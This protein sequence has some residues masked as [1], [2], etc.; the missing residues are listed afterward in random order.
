MIVL[1]VEDSVDSRE[2]MTF[3]LKSNGF[4]VIHAEDGMD[5]VEVAM[6]VKPDVILMDLNLPFVSGWEATRTIRRIPELKDVPIIAISAQT[7]DEWRDAVLA[8][9]AIDCLK[10]PL[11]TNLL[12]E[13]L[14]KYNESS[15]ATKAAA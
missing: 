14:A 13:A 5:A 10:K 12:L 9:G 7:H 3:L 11:D 15:A 4:N 8:A 1:L 2:M 6:L